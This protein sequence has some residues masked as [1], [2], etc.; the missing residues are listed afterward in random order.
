MKYNGPGMLPTFWLLNVAPGFGGYGRGPSNFTNSFEWLGQGPWVSVVCAEPKPQH[1]MIII[2]PSFSSSLLKSV[3]CFSWRRHRMRICGGQVAPL[4]SGRDPY[5][6]L[7]RQMQE[8]TLNT[9]ALN[10]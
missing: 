3:F 5:C 6:Q 1:H 7:G 8:T 2:F 4:I 9:L 10:Y